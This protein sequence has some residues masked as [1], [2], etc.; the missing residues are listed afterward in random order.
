MKSSN[1]CPFGKKLQRYWNNR[2]HYFHRFDEG[3]QTDAEG[4]HTVIPESVAI[5]QAE[6]LSKANIVLDGFCGIGG[7]AIALA[8]RGKRVFTVEL[9]SERLA[10]AKNNARVYGVERFI[11]FIN[12]D[13]FDVAPSINADAAIL[14]PPWGWPRYRKIDVFQ[15]EHFNPDGSK[16]INF[17]LNYFNLILLRTPKNFNTS[18][19]NQFNI[20]YHAYNEMLHNT[21]ISKSIIIKPMRPGMSCL[22][23]TI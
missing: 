20:I 4:L 12:G 9:N 21:I 6:L 15:L 19:L 10:M 14:D 18:E 7:S 1:I 8:R 22:K 5:M 13:F 23:V 11:T 16:I 2:Y 3:I 17:A